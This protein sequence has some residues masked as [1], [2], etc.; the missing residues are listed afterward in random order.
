MAKNQQHTTMFF[1]RTYYYW[2]LTTLYT[3]SRTST[4]VFKSS[5]MLHLL[6]G[7]AQILEIFDDDKERKKESN[8]SW[9]SSVRNTRRLFCFVCLTFV[10]HLPT[11]IA[12]WYCGR[13]RA[14]SIQD[15]SPA[16]LRPID[17]QEQATA[18]PVVYVVNG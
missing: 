14:S 7:S 12:L 18:A 10:L 17:D 2:D 6:T 16:L 9:I 4:Y 13:D 3:H 11:T 15:S 5:L 8:N 1:R